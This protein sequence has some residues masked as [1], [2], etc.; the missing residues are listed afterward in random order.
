MIAE[1]TGFYLIGIIVGVLTAAHAILFVH[2][3]FLF[4]TKV[5]RKMWAYSY[6][7][8][9][10]AILLVLNWILNTQFAT[11]TDQWTRRYFILFWMIPYLISAAWCF[12]KYRKLAGRLR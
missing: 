12:W 2:L 5:L 3:A 4:R 6:I 1:I 11:I 10:L 8:H 9:L 7:L